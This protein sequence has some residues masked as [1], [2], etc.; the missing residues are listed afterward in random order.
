MSLA[1]VK[2]E[3]AKGMG[4]RT[5]LVT[6]GAGFIG[7]HLTEELLKEGHEVTILDNFSNGKKGEHSTLARQSFVNTSQRRFEETEGTGTTCKCVRARFPIWPQT[8][9]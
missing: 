4:E 7:S 9:K 6:G 2:T 8:L 3:A 1:T 5:M